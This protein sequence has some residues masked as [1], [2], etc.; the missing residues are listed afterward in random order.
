[1]EHTRDKVNL[2]TLK[3]HPVPI[4]STIRTTPLTLA[5]EPQYCVKYLLLITAVLAAGRASASGIQQRSM[6]V[7]VRLCSGLPPE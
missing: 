4:L 5:A 7:R 2:L 3:A 1:M 6:N